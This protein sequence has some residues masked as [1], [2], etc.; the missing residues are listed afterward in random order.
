MFEVISIFGEEHLVK[1]IVAIM[2]SNELNFFIMNFVYLWSRETIE[3]ND[4]KDHWV[5]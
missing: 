4:L 5:S 1:N 2:I 3:D